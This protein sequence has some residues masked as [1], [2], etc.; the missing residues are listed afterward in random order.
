MKSKLTATALAVALATGLTVS[1]AQQ[2][3]L[4][5]D[6]VKIGVLTDMSGVYAEYGGQGA[7]TA[8]KMAV[9]DFGGKMFGKPIEVLNADHQNKPRHRQERHPAVV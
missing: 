3:K 6:A 5:N 7:V 4:S 2:G 8:A 9:E 1:N